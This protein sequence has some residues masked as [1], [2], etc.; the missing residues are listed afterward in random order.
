MAESHSFMVLGTRFDV[1]KKYSILDPVGQGAY[2][3]V[4]AAKD[5]ETGELVAIK[6]IERAFEHTTFTLRTLRELKILRLL[7]HENIIAIKSIQLPPSRDDFED[8]YVISE[9]METDLASII[10]SPQPLSDE[11]CQFFLYQILRGMK[12]I[13]SAN[14]LHRDLKPRNL[15]VNSNCDLKICDFGLARVDFGHDSRFTT[16]AMTDY[17]ATRWYR[18]PEVLLAY[19]KYSKSIDMWSIG[20]IFAELLNRRPL[21]P[22]NDTQHQLEIITNA[23]GTPPEDEIRKYHA[24][25]RQFMLSLG[26][27]SPKTFESLFPDANPTALDLLR[28]MLTFDPAKRISVTEALQH[29]Y[30][31]ALHCPEDEPIAEPVS[32]RE[33]DFERPLLSS[34]DLRELIYEE[35]L[36]YHPEVAAQYA[37]KK[38]RE[39]GALGRT[40]DLEHALEHDVG[41]DD[42]Y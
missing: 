42:D 15:L 41:S 37:E 13:H 4:C 33:F 3:V 36:N 5:E 8:I 29:P 10:K 24:K 23:L 14:I 12:Y 2:G 30:L 25:S 6:K 7:A 21:F 38:A 26:K 20:C 11:H 18:P 34:E 22:G 16:K 17:V 27:K 32:K 9:L 1:E 40:K 19:R 28:K 39:N 35:I 31:A